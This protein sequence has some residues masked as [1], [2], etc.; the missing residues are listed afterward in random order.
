MLHSTL[1][2]TALSLPAESCI[3]L[4]QRSMRLDQ[5]A[6]SLSSHRPS[7]LRMRRSWRILRR[8]CCIMRMSRRDWREGPDCTSRDYHQTMSTTKRPRRTR[9]SMLLFKLDHMLTRLGLNGLKGFNV[10]GSRV[11]LTAPAGQSNLKAFAYIPN[12]SVMTIAM[13]RLSRTFHE[14]SLIFAG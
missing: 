9:V 5:A 3:S 6:T 8:K 4:F 10:T 7:R 12:P 1:S 13:A 14:L 2:P 11:N